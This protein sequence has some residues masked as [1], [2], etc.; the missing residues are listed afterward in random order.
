LVD[1][2]SDNSTYFFAFSTSGQLLVRA[3]LLL[4]GPVVAPFFPLFNA[5]VT[6]LQRGKM[7]KEK[8]GHRTHD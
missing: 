3:L 5:L 1:E 7:S 4:A 2:G 8:M 6:L